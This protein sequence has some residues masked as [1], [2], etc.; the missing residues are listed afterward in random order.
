[1]RSL[2]EN[3]YPYNLYHSTTSQCV[4]INIIKKKT[5][6]AKVPVFNFVNIDFSFFIFELLNVLI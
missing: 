6:L 5:M 2:L 1:M 3:N 4:D